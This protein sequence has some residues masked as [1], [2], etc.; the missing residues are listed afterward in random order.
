MYWKY[1]IYSSEKQIQG[2]WPAVDG[3]RI[4]EDNI[5]PDLIANGF[6]G[7]SVS[8]PIVFKQIIN[9]SLVI[10][11]IEV[12]QLNSPSIITNYWAYDYGENRGESINPTKYP[13]LTTL[14]VPVTDLN[15]II[16]DNGGLVAVA[17]NGSI[18]RWRNEIVQIEFDYE[19]FNSDYNIV[20]SEVPRWNPSGTESSLVVDC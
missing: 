6:D 18:W 15:S 8:S 20:S 7:I 10:F 5:N 13:F 3:F 14:P 19:Q 9:G 16:E 1:K 2:N 17:R 11:F 12:Y 4:V